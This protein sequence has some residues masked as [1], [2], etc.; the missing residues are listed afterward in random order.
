MTE[1]TAGDPVA[2]QTGAGARRLTP[3]D[4]FKLIF[5]SDPRISPD[6]ATIAYVRTVIEGETHEYRSA[7]WVV[8]ATGGEG[9]PFTAGPKA[10]T[11]PRWSPGGER[12]AFV[13]DRSGEKQLWVMEWAGGEARQLTTMR[14]GATGPVWSPD[15]KS[16]AFLASGAAGDDVATLSRERTAKE[17]E[18]E[19]KA[20]KDRP[21]TVTRLK[22]KADDAFGLPDGKYRHLWVVDVPA[23][24]ADPNSRARP[25]QL[26]S[27]AF[28]VAEPAWAPDGRQ[29]AFSAN[30]LP[31]ADRHPTI[32]DIHIV[33]AA[34]GEARRLTAGT[35]TFHAPGWSPDGS[36]LLCVGHHGEFGLATLDGLWSLEV[37]TGRLTCLTAGLDLSVGDQAIG[38]VR[39]GASATGPVWVEDGNAI[40][41]P[42]SRHGTTQLFR[43][44]VPDGSVHQLTTGQLWIY[45]FTI[46]RAGSQAAIGIAT[47]ESPGDVG[48]VDLA[49]A[50]VE[51]LTAVNAWLAREVWLARPEE[52]WF[53]GAGSRPIQGWIMPPVGKAPGRRYPLIL[54]IHGGPHA[55]YGPAFFFEFQLLAAEGYGVVFTNPR[56]SHGYGQ[57]FV[58]AVVGHYGEDDYAD[59]M[60]AVDHVA[61]LDWVDVSR[62][63]VTGGS[64]G[65]YMTNWIV[66]HTHRFRAAVTQRSI[67]NWISFYGVSDIGYYFAGQELGA[68]PASDPGRLLQL[69]PISYA[70]DVTTPLLILHSEQ[71]MRCPMEQAEQLFVLLKALDKETELVRFPGANHNLSR[72]G[73]PVLR[74]ERLRRI[75]GWFHRYLGTVP[76]DYVLPEA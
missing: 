24:P 60:A 56:G 49:T 41:F 32:Q 39:F 68:T 53:P 50:S 38:D 28:D 12:L 27:G 58:H 61:G 36:R 10:D 71:D 75:L 5:V 70:R 22:Y 59:L 72:G 19:E 47:P 1:A 35:G 46:D 33:P 37:E 48:I 6:G 26:T 52:F 25:R 34:G 65:G 11:S 62:L 16:L 43:L 69:S 45:G 57:E 30:C 18:E 31:G 23:S 74:V 76:G 8:P 73:R 54:E 4:L 21:V 67:S 17:K 64:Y 40:I 66:G 13:S 51:T 42:A 9:R 29:L 44:T 15:G 63:G 2:A 3:D 20:R 7:I 14:Y 55:M